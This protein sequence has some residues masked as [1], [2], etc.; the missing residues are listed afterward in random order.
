[1]GRM[2][3]L[4]SASWMNWAGQED[5][6]I[7]VVPAHQ[8][9]GADDAPV[10]QR[11]E[12]LVV[13]LDL[14]ALDDVVE[15]GVEVEAD[16]PSGLPCGRR[17]T[18]RSDHR[19]PAP[20]PDTWPRRRRAEGRRGTCRTRSA[21]RR[22]SWWRPPRVR[23]LSDDR[24]AEGVEDG[25]GDLAGVVGRGHPLEQDHELVAAEPRQRVARPHGTAQAVPDHPSNS[26]PTWWPRLSL[27]TLKRS[28]SQNRT[29]TWLPVR[30]ACKQGVVEVVEEEPPVGQAG[31]ARPGMRGGPAA[32]RT[33]CAPTCRGRR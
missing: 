33:P 23:A 14:A 30:S 20:W 8:C 7:G 1:M 11:D 6:V 21:R 3:P 31:Q 28:M 9:L 22:C 12:R 19:G 27:T 16:R 10:G 15:R 32:P 5:A 17:R 13:D 26:S 25:V 24:V 4:S 29:A 18:G 2:V